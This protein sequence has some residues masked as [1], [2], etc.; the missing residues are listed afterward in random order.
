[1]KLINGAIGIRGDFTWTAEQIAD[2]TVSAEVNYLNAISERKITNNSKTAIFKVYDTPPENLALRK[3]AI[4]SSIEGVG[5]EASKAVDGNF[6]TRWSSQFS[7]PQW[8]VIDL[9]STQTFNQIRLYW[10]TAYGKEYKIQISDNGTNW[11]DIIH[12]TNGVGGIEKYDLQTSARFIRI[13]GIRR[14]TGWGYSLYE[15]EIYFSEMTSDR[16]ENNLPEIKD[17]VLYQNYPN[18]FNPS[19]I[20][21]YQMPGSGHVTIKVYNAL[22]QEV[23]TLVNEEKPAG[24]YYVEFNTGNLSSGIYFYKMSSG[25]FTDSRKLTL[26]R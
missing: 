10:E 23:A 15:V 6:S 21:T 16:D 20:I 19:T 3:L 2:F 4:A 26:M 5:L 9:G 25:E 13:Y 22:G 24:N 17:Y 8:L 7:D 1:M 11:T 12:Q 14:G 18:P